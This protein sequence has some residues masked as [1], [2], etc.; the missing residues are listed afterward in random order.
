MNERSIQSSAGFTLV[1]LLIGM[2]LALMVMGAVLSSYTFMGRNLYRLVNQQSLQ[3]DA[4]R[5]LQYFEQDVDLA[6]GI[7]GTPS[8][9]SLVLIIPTSSTGSTTTITWSYSS[10]SK[11]L[12]RTLASGSSLTLLSNLTSCAFS[13]YD[14][15]GN[16]YTSATLSAGSYLSSIKQVAL[17][18]STKTGQNTDGSNSPQTATYQ[19]S[20][21]RLILRNQAF[22]E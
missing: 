6:S 17:S 1:E 7:S 22:L 14:K 12:T 9:S 5:T 13:Y 8:A 20:S 2:S 3:T 4:R 18:F 21:A 16:P 11:T 19:A 15:S 10:S